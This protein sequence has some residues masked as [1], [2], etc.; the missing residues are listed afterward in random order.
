MEKKIYVPTEEE[1]YTM[2]EMGANVYKYLMIKAVESII[3]DGKNYPSKGILKNAYQYVQE[4][5][6]LSYMISLMYPNEVQYSKRARNN[7]DLA[8]R[9]NILLM[10]HAKSMV[11]G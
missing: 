7:K 6:Y 3:L 2:Q 11:K 10:L 1:L 8:I 5:P 9:L 4:D